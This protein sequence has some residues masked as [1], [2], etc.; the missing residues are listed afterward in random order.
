MDENTKKT[1]MLNGLIIGGLMSL[2]FLLSTSKIGFLSFFALVVSVGILFYMYRFAVNYRDK[3]NAGVI[4]YKQAFIFLFQIYFLGSI[5]LSLI[6]L[7]YT[8]FINKEYLETMVNETLK[9]Y[10]TI[11]FSIDD[12]TIGLMET[13]YKPAP[14]A[15]LNLFSSAFG[16]A[17]W[18]LIFAAFI[19]KEKSIFEQRLDEL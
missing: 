18:A 9:M 17:F 1:A 7:L 19:K 11:G 3:D 2:K 6:I 16:G 5:V 10:E 14:F 4:S 12:N 15:L 13:A 8:T